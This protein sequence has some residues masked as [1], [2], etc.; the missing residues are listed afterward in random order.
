MAE[1]II[2]DTATVTASGRRKTRAGYLVTQARVAKAG[3]IQV[4]TGAEAGMP[5][6]ATVRIYRPEEAVFDHQTVAAWAF[7]PIT[8]QHPRS[9]SVSSQNWRDEAIGVAG[10]EVMRDGDFLSIPMCIMDAAGIDAIESGVATEVS[11][12]YR[13][14]LDYEP[15]TTPSG[16]QFDAK[17]VKI[18][19]DHLAIVPKG[20]AGSECRIGDSANSTPT[21]TLPKPTRKDHSAMADE[22]TGRA[23]ILVDGFTV[24]TTPQGRE[25]IQRL[26]TQLNDARAETE[27][28]KSVNQQALDSL[29]GQL[30][31]ARQALVD[32]TAKKEGD[33]AGLKLQHQTALDAANARVAELEQQTT[34][35]ALE[36]L[37]ASR[38]ATVAVARR[39]LGDTFTGAG[40]SDA[41]IRRQTVLKAVGTTL[42][43][44][45]AKPQLFFDHVFE[46]VAATPAPQPAPAPARPDP[47]RIALATNPGPI[48]LDAAKQE[49]SPLDKHIA[50]LSKAYLN[51]PAN[52]VI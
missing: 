48:A 37:A 1:L 32:E 23:V 26:Q 33:L 51:V 25:A 17:I 35:A 30:A 49:P 20:R 8:L 28:F 22:N 29:N 2:S 11:C 18:V 36:A 6:K 5:D 15:G 10:G 27:K 16:E 41:D 39:V 47:M 46:A 52:G 19:P 14:A 34:P 50:R 38:A 45:E 40:M 12:G 9:G 43:D 44:A 24:E 42:A 21:P 4:Y 31:A 13:V 7:K 3:N